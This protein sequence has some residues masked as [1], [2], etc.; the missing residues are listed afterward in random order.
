MTS[1]KE[2]LPI[3]QAT[4]DKEALLGSDD[5]HQD[6]DDGASTEQP[7]A[8]SSAPAAAAA[9][10]TAALSAGHNSDSDE[11]ISSASASVAP[12]LKQGTSNE[13]QEGRRK[14]PA[15]AS[16]RRRRNKKRKKKVGKE[17]PKMERSKQVGAHLRG[18]IYSKV[19]N[20][21]GAGIQSVAPLY[22]VDDELD[23]GGQDKLK[24]KPSFNTLVGGIM[25][26]SGSMLLASWTAAIK[27]WTGSWVRFF[28]LFSFLVSL[29]PFSF[30]LCSV[31]RS[32]S[33]SWGFLSSFL[34]ACLCECARVSLARRLAAPPLPN[35]TRPERHYFVEIHNFPPRK[36]ARLYSKSIS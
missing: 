34:L 29:F 19:A 15:G 9:A 32:R 5:G 14:E 7:S 4:A 28:S 27:G 6:E 23:D 24:V 35:L 3:E 25:L 20:P 36:G 22:V 16:S 33:L 26:S 13:D 8:L 30:C 2:S 10:A 31:S 12:L 1:L 11:D 18:S 21:G 17:G